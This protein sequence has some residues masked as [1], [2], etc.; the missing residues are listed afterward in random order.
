MV[1][2]TGREQRKPMSLVFLSL[3]RGQKLHLIP[4]AIDDGAVDVK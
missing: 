4:D 1:V 3:K 2:H